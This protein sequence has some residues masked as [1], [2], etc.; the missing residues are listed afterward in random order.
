MVYSPTRMSLGGPNLDFVFKDIQTSEMIVGELWMIVQY[1]LELFYGN[2][3]GMI[4]GYYWNGLPS[5]N[6][7]IAMEDTPYRSHYLIRISS[8]TIRGRD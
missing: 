4:L 3:N 7:T 8:I 5:G 6:Q 2:N 1:D